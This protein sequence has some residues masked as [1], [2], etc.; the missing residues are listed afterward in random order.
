[1]MLAT[2]AIRVVSG[3]LSPEFEWAVRD[4]RLVAWDIETSGLDWATDQIATCQLHVADIGTEVVRLNDAVP[5]RLRDLLNSERVVKV[6][7]HAAFDLR[8][9]RHHWRIAPRGVA[10]TKILSKIVHP[11][12]AG[13]EHSLKPVLSRYLG[14]ELDKTQQVSDW[15]AE[16]LSEEQLRY[17]VRDVE[18][19]LPLFDR[20]MGAA[21]ANG[22]AD[23]VEQSFAYLPTR[24]ET[25]L[26]GSGDVFAY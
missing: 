21:R 9:M 6:F 17:A 14:V 16:D 20:L 13:R 2:G 7:H 12:L 11:G 26:R 4:A 8:F 18:F 5:D 23:L 22:V 25:D 19:L 3:D 10:C 24:V 1:M 15:F